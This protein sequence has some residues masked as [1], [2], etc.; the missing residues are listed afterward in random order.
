M[1]DAEEEPLPSAEQH[2]PVATLSK[3]AQKRLVKQAQWEERKQA[4]KAQRKAK[5]K[6]ESEQRRADLQQVRT[7]AAASSSLFC[8]RL[9]TLSAA[10]STRRCWTV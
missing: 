6:Q 3:N 7:A 4:M 8:L 1:T 5:A 9:H 2:V 10:L